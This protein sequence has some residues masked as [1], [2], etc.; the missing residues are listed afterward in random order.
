MTNEV[1]MADAA[2][3]PRKKVINRTVKLYTYQEKVTDAVFEAF[4]GKGPKDD[5]R[6]SV[7]APTGSGK[8]VMM[9][10]IIRDM[11]A[12]SHEAFKQNARDQEVA[13]EEEGSD[14]ERETIEYEKEQVLILVPTIQIAT[15]MKAEAKRILKK[16][17]KVNCEIELEQGET[18]SDGT[19][20]L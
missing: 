15:Q 8:T 7:C 4:A 17:F 13:D 2:P 1:D 19:A 18:R 14:E 20:D 12:K 6:I 9:L 16:D 11:W 5:V 3:R 10:S